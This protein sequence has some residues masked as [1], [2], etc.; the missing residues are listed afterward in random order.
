MAKS[1]GKHKRDEPAMV[2]HMKQDWRKDKYVIEFLVYCRKSKQN[3]HSESSYVQREE[4]FYDWGT[5]EDDEFDEVGYQEGFQEM[6]EE[7]EERL[8]REDQQKARKARKAKRRQRLS[9]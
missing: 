1:G 4:E 8:R 7:L 6:M 2:E 3:K 5:P 9:V